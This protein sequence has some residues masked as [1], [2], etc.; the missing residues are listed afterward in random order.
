VVPSPELLLAL[1]LALGGEAAGVEIAGSD[2]AGATEAALSEP[3]SFEEL[4]APSR[5]TE[6]SP[7]TRLGTMRRGIKEVALRRESHLLAHS[8][9]RPASAISATDRHDAVL[10]GEDDTAITK[11]RTGCVK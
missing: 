8:V 7:A 4:H 10:T 9:R 6:A 2:A 5:S 3:A 11:V 1:A